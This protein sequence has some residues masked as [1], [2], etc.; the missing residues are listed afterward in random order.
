MNWRVEHA[1]EFEPEFETLPNAVKVSI[2]A[3]IENLQE[4][5]L[6]AG[7]PHVATLNGSRHLTMMEM[8]FTAAAGTWRVAFAFD[9]ARNAILLVAADK[10]GVSSKRFYRS[11]IQRA[12]HRFDLHL[13]PRHHGTMLMHN[14]LQEY[15]DNLNE[16][17]REEVDRI[18]AQFL[19]NEKAYRRSYAAPAAASNVLLTASTPRAR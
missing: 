3:L 8:R 4:R 14:T 18:K 10:S 1:P 12:D 15:I 6:H 17:D 19:T 5:V 13:A 9:P 16:T 7:S 11:L 2:A